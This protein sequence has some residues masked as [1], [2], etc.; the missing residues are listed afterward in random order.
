MLSGT[1]TF[2]VT[3]SN[4]YG[5][6]QV[7]VTV[8]GVLMDTQ[9]GPRPNGAWTFSIDTTKYSGT[10]ASPQMHTV[11][12]IAYDLGGNTFTT[13]QTITIAN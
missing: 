3:A 5:V 10:I 8:D 12:A 6:A 2:T 11:E 1:H 7:T 9:T 13:S 4:T